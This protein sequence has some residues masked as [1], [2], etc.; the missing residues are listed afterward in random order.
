VI[1]G[2]LVSALSFRLVRSREVQTSREEFHLQASTSE[3]A[4]RREIGANLAALRSLRAYIDVTPNLRPADF[5]AFAKETMGMNQS[6]LSLEWAP[7]VSGPNRAAFERRLLDRGVQHAYIR[8]TLTTTPRRAAE[9]NQYFPVEMMSPPQEA[10]RVLGFDL[11]SSLATARVLERAQSTRKLTAGGKVAVVELSHSRFAMPT[12]MAVFEG[13]PGHDRI[14]GFVLGLFQMEVVLEK[15][16]RRFK[17]DAID[18]DFY[19]LSASPGNRFLF[20]HASAN[21]AD[22]MVRGYSSETQAL[23]EGDFKQIARFDVGGRHWAMVMTATPA[24]LGPGRTW[25][26]WS[27]LAILLTVTGVVSVLF[28]THV[29]RSRHEEELRLLRSRKESEDALRISEER[30]ALAARGSRDGLWDWDLKTGLIYYSDRWKS[31]LGL[32]DEEVTN[33]PDEWLERLYPADRTRIQ[34][35][36]ARHCSGETEHFQSEYRILHKDGSYRWM[37]S[38]GVAVLSDSGAAT[39]L[40][41]SQT[42]ITENKAADPL[43]GLASRLLL[44]E[45][46]QLTIDQARVN[47]EEEFALLF[48]DLDRFKVIND[49][50]GHHAGDRLLLEIAQRLLR[51]VAEEPFSQARTLVAR[52]GGD[53]F[54]VLIAGVGAVSLSTMLAD[55]IQEAMGPAFDLDGHHMF[56]SASIGFRT[57][58][59]HVTPETLLL[60]ADT[61]MYHAKA[62]GKQRSELLFRR[63]A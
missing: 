13:P 58:S 18:F 25:L 63:C 22:T 53:E 16:L 49:S 10:E 62:Q 4:V 1:T 48:L 24:Y 29:T 34:T 54:V 55:R 37:L 21:E 33:S 23:A 43:T 51:C 28:L 5:E 40:A 7:R 46:L 26:S 27:I 2:I 14:R 47:S 32:D 61:A 19:D 38:R 42:D 31:M 20:H 3:Y 30:Y 56:I 6:I 45:R 15:G 36:I 8:R 52:L 17:P 39:R 11:S 57:G 50:L 41:G 9:A 59:P 44:N 12:Y 60:D 35:E